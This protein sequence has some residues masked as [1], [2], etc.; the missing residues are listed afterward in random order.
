MLMFMLSDFHYRIGHQCQCAHIEKAQTTRNA[1]ICSLYLMEISKEKT[2]WN[3]SSDQPTLTEA[4]MGIWLNAGDLSAG[5]A[6]LQTGLRRD[7]TPCH[8]QEMFLRGV[9]ASEAWPKSEAES[10][11]S[12]P[13][14]VLFH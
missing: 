5:S 8:T 3:C 1:N 9:V 14:A 11:R 6:C 12:V 7:W 13:V 2:V 4:L 10:T